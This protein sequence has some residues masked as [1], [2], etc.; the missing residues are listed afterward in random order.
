MLLILFLLKRGCV[1]D[2]FVYFLYKAVY[3]I[4]IFQ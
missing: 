2:E 4:N 3:K 1:I